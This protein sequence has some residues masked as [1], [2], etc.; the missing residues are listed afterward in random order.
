MQG[1]TAVPLL[2]VEDVVLLTVTAA[3]DEVRLV[4]AVTPT[5]LDAIAPYLGQSSVIVVQQIP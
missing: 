3:E 5:D 4:T 1:E 2:R